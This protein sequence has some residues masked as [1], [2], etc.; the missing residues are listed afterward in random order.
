MTERIYLE[1]IENE[2][3]TTKRARAQKAL[4]EKR[5]EQERLETKASARVDHWI[6][7]L[8][9]EYIKEKIIDAKAKGREQATLVAGYEVI[10][11]GFDARRLFYDRI[12]DQPESLKRR[13]ESFID[14]EALQIYCIDELSSHNFC[15][16][17]H[18]GTYMYVPTVI[19]KRPL[20]SFVVLLGLI[21]HFSLLVSFFKVSA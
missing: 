6:S 14:T 7:V 8:T 2:I 18:W 4:L 3:Q 16:N 11:S 19:S 12:G 20:T 5:A 1:D 13:L 9:P 21:F 10:G 15:L 17:I